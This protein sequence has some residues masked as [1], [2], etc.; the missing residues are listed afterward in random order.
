M[1]R[2]GALL[3]VRL[4]AL[5]GLGAACASS[6]VPATAD[7]GDPDGGAGPDGAGDGPA[8]AGFGD[9]CAVGSDCASGY[10]YHAEPS[11]PAG[12]CTDPCTT[13]CPDGLECKTVPLGNGVEAMLCV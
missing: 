2:K 4:G 13:A 7:G 12:I 8:R 11:N 5:L 3:A 6:S 1:D 10:C 9:P